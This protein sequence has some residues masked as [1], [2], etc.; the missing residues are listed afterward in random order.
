MLQSKNRV[1]DGLKKQ[2]PSIC[3][4][5]EAHFRP[6]DTCILKVRGQGN[7]QH[8]NGC[9]KRA[10]VEI[11]KLDKLDFKPDCSKR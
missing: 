3:C 10:G 11:L 1:T 6:K 8:T 7:V 4:L 2:V 5:Q 9:Q